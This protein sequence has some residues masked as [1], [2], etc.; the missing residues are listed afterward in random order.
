MYLPKTRK[1]PNE[2][3]L[4]PKRA[5]TLAGGF[6]LL[7]LSL[8]PVYN[9]ITLLFNPNYVF[10]V[11]KALPLG[12]IAFCLGLIGLY[13]VTMSV[14]FNYVPPIFQ[15]E[16]IMLITST[17]FVAVLGM[18][19]L[20]FSMP[21]VHAMQETS[22]NLLHRCDYSLQ[23]H[24]LYTYAQSLQNARLTPACQSRYT[25]E[26]CIG[27]EAVEPYASYLKTLETSYRCA[28][29][30][31]I[32]TFEQN[33]TAPSLYSNKINRISCDGTAVR[34]LKNV[35]GSIGGELFFQGM[36]TALIAFLVGVSHLCTGNLFYEKELE[37]SIIQP[38]ENP[39]FEPE[40]RSAKEVAA[41]VYCAPQ[42]ANSV[43][44][45]FD[46]LD[47]NGD[48]RLS[49]E[50]FEAF[51]RSQA[52]A[53]PTPMYVPSDLLQMP[54]ATPAPYRSI[55]AM[56]APTSMYVPSNT[57][58]VPAPMPTYV[59]SNLLPMPPR[60][61][62]DALFDAFDRDGDGRLSKEEFEEFQRSQVARV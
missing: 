41:S 55:Q 44:D 56:P 12:I 62:T 35:L 34:D 5:V 46:R 52:P 58:P 18:A 40:L 29:W 4:T 6:F 13:M 60:T 59:S 2:D 38:L 16:H 47:T 39:A 23:T 36:L 32:T 8:M 43:D 31:Y 30:C 28:G 14:F 21:M 27:Y 19:L 26:E 17:T 11:G 24:D 7:V 54:A 9:C 42:P 15:T 1:N 20:I 53:L 51:Q 33:F 48:G 57:L 25:I 10:W 49:R 45:L 50:E 37:A 3:F 22:N 61:P